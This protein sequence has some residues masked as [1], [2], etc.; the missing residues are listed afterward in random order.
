MRY[1][2]GLSDLI[3]SS[4]VVIIG[5]VGSFMIRALK[6]QEKADTKSRHIKFQMTLNSLPANPLTDF[7][8]S[9]NILHSSSAKIT[10]YGMRNILV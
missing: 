5:G 1:K 4:L 10:P 2:N 3:H 8:D 6:L 7:G 9:P